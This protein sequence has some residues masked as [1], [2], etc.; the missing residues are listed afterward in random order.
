[1]AVASSPRFEARPGLAV[2]KGNRVWIAYEE[3]D[4]NWG[5]DYGSLAPG[6]GNPLYSARSVRV[7]CLDTDGKLAIATAEAEWK[8]V[9][10]SNLND[11]CYATPAIVS[12]SGSQ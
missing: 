11:R 6:K 8:V 9:G 10:T 3:G 4:E 1:M 12:G 7:V 5:K 2:D